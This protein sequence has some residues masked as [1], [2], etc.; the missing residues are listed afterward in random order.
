MLIQAIRRK[1]VLEI[2]VGAVLGYQQMRKSLIDNLGGVLCKNLDRA[3]ACQTGLVLL[4][5][6]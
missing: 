2:W 5:N 6:Q 4:F 1:S 3:I